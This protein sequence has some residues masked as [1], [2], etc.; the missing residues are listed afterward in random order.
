MSRET[1]AE[2]VAVVLTLGI[3]ASP[4]RAEP[5]KLTNPQMDNV[6]AGAFSVVGGN[7]NTL[8]GFH[9]GANISLLSTNNG[10]SYMDTAGTTWTTQVLYISPT[11]GVAVGVLTNPQGQYWD[12]EFQL[13]PN[14]LMTPTQTR[15]ALIPTPIG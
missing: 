7:L 4:V 11:Q 12:G 10:A 2:T 6:T 1:A 8:V 3:L 13:P 14:Y 9:N 5:V 15:G